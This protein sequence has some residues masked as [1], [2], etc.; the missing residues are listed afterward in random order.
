[1]REMC[2]SQLSHVCNLNHKSTSLPHT[3]FFAHVS[4]MNCW[5]CIHKYNSTCMNKTQSL[6]I[7][8]RK[9][10]KCVMPRDS[11]LYHN[12]KFKFSSKE[13]LFLVSSSFGLYFVFDFTDSNKQTISKV[14]EEGLPSTNSGKTKTIKELLN[15]T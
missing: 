10:L 4:F 3:S 9:C 13:M 14:Y 8:F 11:F 2:T 1:M 7:Q 12:T 5:S 6:F 15:V